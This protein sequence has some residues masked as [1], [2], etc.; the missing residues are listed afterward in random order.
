MRGDLLIIG[1]GATGVSVFANAVR[2]AHH[3]SIRLIDP[4]EVGRGVAFGET[5]PDLLTNSS[6]EVN[7][8]FV[9]EPYDFVDYLRGHG[10]SYTPQDV[11]PRRYLGEYCAQ[12]FEEHA[13][14]ARARGTRVERSRAR[15]LS[16]GRDG[17]GYR[18]RLSDGSEVR[19]SD[20]V[21][22]SGLE[23]PRL[24]DLMRE[25][26][27]HPAFTVGSFP[28]ERL[29]RRVPTASRVL[30]IGSRQSAVDA[31]LLLCG[32]GDRV[33]MTS[34]S[35]ALPSV[36][37]RTPLLPAAVTAPAR[38]RELP[39]SGTNPVPELTRIFVRS[40]RQGDA[41]PLAE[42][43]TAESDP[44]RRLRAEIALAESGACAWQDIAVGVSAEL[45]DWLP[46]LPAAT[47]SE[48]LA[49]FRET[50]RRYATALI[51]P[52][53]RKM[54]GHIDGGALELA[55]THPAR[56]SRQGA[57]WA[58]EWPDGRTRTFDHVVSACGYEPPTL[59]RDPLNGD[60]HLDGAPR[61]AVRVDHLGPDLRVRASADA[62]PEN[63]WIVGAG[64]HVRV[65][66]FATLL[67]VA[68]RQA[69][70]VAAQL[71]SP[72]EPASREPAFAAGR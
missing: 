15:A 33:T 66:F 27:G 58:V 63:V 39:V 54:L 1:A 62:Q 2:H 7:S 61:H 20:V 32:Q 38:I 47:R 48:V 44:V 43:F 31:A 17:E 45:A 55:P 72:A 52:N 24:P 51:L 42:Q 70:D 37:T 67:Y 23:R 49:A 34:P 12:R 28:A 13:A 68:A 14:L 50:G 26:E 9:D 6:C 46:T 10:L 40:V 8:L 11:V 29:L 30:L 56:V 35:G 3:R 41:R 22:C 19:G 21:I 69:R 18:V 71:A 65:L 25:H 36:R 53:A 16:I 60:I 59:W 4:R 57:E 5:H 64:T